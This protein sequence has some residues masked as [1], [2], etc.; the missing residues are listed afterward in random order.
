MAEGTL[1]WF[2][3]SE[4]IDH[5]KQGTHGRNE[6]SRLNFICVVNYFYECM[7]VSRAFNNFNA[8]IYR[9]EKSKQILVCMDSKLQLRP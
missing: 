4:R 2:I 6:K 7:F 9:L 8:F 3:C 5:S 1:L